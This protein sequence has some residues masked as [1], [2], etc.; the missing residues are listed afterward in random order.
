MSMTIHLG[1]W[2]LPT[3]ITLGSFGA[4]LFLERRESAR[5][6]RGGDYNFSGAFHGL[7]AGLLLL[8]ASVLSLAAWLVWALF[9]GAA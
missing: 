1:W 3:I 5:L 9:G 8:L 2:L 7:F 6:P 4:A